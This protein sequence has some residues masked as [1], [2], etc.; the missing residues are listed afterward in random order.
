MGSLGLVGYRAPTGIGYLARR[1]ARKLPI[2]RWMA[3]RHPADDG[4]Q[5]PHIQVVGW[6]PSPV[7]TQRFLRG[8]STILAIERCW[9]PKLFSQALGLGIRCVLLVMGE[10]FDRRLGRQANL[11]IAPTLL[12][13]RQLES[14]GF[15][16][17]TVYVPMPLDLEEFPFVQRTV[18]RHFLF[19]DGWGGCRERKGAPLIRQLLEAEPDLVQVRSQRKPVYPVGAQVLGP[20]RN[21][22]DL[23]HGADVCVQPS[24]WEG[25]GLQ[26]LEAM[27]S[28]LPVITTNAPPMSEHCI[29]AHGRQ[30]AK[31]RLL[32]G[33]KIAFRYVS[34][35]RWPDAFC[36]VDSLR[37]LIHGLRGSDISDLSLQGRR[38]IEREHGEKQWGTLK[39][40]LA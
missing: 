4:F 17:K 28:G 22:V 37:S 26:Q 12:C 24:R 33:C 32:C 36:H 38:Y 18:A 40:L 3:P 23:Y 20:V 10:W 2:D 13:Y 7:D 11:L 5:D 25:L 14:W 8:L 30:I 31:Q 9:P 19:C 39:T 34:L 35:E 21:P 27:A 29:S 1:I 15:A 16:D 6:K